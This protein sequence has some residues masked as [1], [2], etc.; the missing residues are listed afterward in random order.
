MY[1]ES[2]FPPITEFTTL[3]DFPVAAVS[4]DM[5][6]AL[7]YGMSVMDNEHCIYLSV[8]MSQLNSRHTAKLNKKS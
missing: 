1:P 6:N 7:G 8:S 2:T 4:I 5:N 3:F